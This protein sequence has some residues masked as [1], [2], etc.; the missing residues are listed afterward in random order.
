MTGSMLDPSVHARLA[1]ILPGESLLTQA[2]ATRPYECDGLSAYRTQPAAVAL[3]ENEE[4]VAALLRVCH[5]CH[6]PVV[7]RGAGTSLSGGAM[8]H[9]RGIVLS[10]AKFNRILDVDP[11]SRTAIVQPGVRNAAISEA[12]AP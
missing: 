5:A 2:E 12:A 8:P 11:V 10:M 9:E 3:P 1:A 7:A 4:Q 6:V